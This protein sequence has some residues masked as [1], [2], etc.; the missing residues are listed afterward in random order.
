[1]TSVIKVVDNYYFQKA[2]KRKHLLLVFLFLPK[3][4][5][6]NFILT[7][8]ILSAAVLSAALLLGLLAG[9]PLGHLARNQST[10]PPNT[11]QQNK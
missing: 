11:M 10:P 5:Q 7:Q 4:D 1:M 6:E 2:T 9:L 3:N 8:E